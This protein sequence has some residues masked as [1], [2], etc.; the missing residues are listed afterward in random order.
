MA[1]HDSA[2]RDTGVRKTA[3]RRSKRLLFDLIILLI[4]PIGGYI[5]ALSLCALLSGVG[6][7]V[8]GMDLDRRL[9]KPHRHFESL[10]LEIKP[11]DMMAR[12]R[13]SFV[14]K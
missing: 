4:V 8:C 9:P 1:P 2:S 3:W 10:M 12:L 5:S 14:N 6:T 13:S 7:D 11:C